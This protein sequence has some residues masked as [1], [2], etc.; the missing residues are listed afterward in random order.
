MRLYCTYFNFYRYHKGL[1][2]EKEKGILGKRAPAEEC[3]ITKKKWKF[4]ELLNYRS[5]KNVN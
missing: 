4:T 1:R 5:L 3:R 2:S